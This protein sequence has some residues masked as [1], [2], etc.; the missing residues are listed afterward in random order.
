MKHHI[1]VLFFLLSVVE[2][3]IVN[4]PTTTSK[5]Q[6][7]SIYSKG[8]DV[9]ENR[10]ASSRRETIIK[11]SSAII[12]SLVGILSAEPALADDAQPQQGRLIEFIV[13]NLNGEPGNSGRFVI[14]TNPEWAP[15][16]VRR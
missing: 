9:Q 14:K 6:L 1:T 3:F 11:T 4:A 2:A 5:V 8:S 15:N 10:V 16:G 12:T 7:T 13:E